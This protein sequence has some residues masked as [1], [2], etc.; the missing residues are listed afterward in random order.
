[1]IALVINSGSSSLKFHLIQIKDKKIIA[2]GIAEWSGLA[3]NYNLNTAG[4]SQN[5][6]LPFVRAKPCFNHIITDLQTKLPLEMSLLVV[7][8]HRVV[9]GGNLTKATLLDQ[10]SIL[11]IKN[12]S[13]F[14]P[15]H[16]PPAL[17]VIEEVAILFPNLKQIACF[18]TAFHSTM[19]REA[20][21]YPIPFN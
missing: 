5:T 12:A 19:P 2:H 14:A 17:E 21:T 6:T 15:L 3:C 13:Y 7:I 20:Y 11:E 8:G 1:M 9:H 16:N 18:D 4:N 10:S